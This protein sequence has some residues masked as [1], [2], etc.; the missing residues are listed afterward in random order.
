MIY[1]QSMESVPYNQRGQRAHPARLA[2]VI[3]ANISKPEPN[4]RPPGPLS[5]HRNSPISISLGRVGDA[6]QGSPPVAIAK[7]VLSSSAHLQDFQAFLLGFHGFFPGISPL[8]DGHDGFAD[9]VP[10]FGDLD[11]QGVGLVHRG[12]GDG[13]GE[14]V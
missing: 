9:G 1:T 2:P 8:D 4:A 7:R 13:F 11:D 3:L 14:G 6:G 10:G 5:K 12:G